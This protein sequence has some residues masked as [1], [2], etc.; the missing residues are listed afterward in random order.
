VGAKGCVLN[1]AAGEDLRKA[2][3]TI[4]R[5]SNYFSEKIAKIAARYVPRKG[6]DSSAV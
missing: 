4:H 1:D 3:H 5:G 6:N 2:I